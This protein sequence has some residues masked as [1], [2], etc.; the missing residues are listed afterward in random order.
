MRSRIEIDGDSM[1]IEMRETQWFL[2]IFLG[3]WLTGW[4]VA[5]VVLAQ[6]FVEKS[7]LVTLMFGV[8]F[9]TSWI[10]VAGVFLNSLIGRQ[11]LLFDQCGLRHTWD[12]IVTL[13]QRS[14]PLEEIRQ[15]SVKTLNVDSEGGATIGIVV[16]TRGRDL[17]FGQNLNRLERDWIA[18]QLDN[19]RKQLQERGRVDVLSDVDPAD[20]R[21][22]APPSDS[23]WDVDQ[24]QSALVICQNGKFVWGAVLGLLFVNAFWNGIVGLFVALLFGFVPGGHRHL[25]GEW[26]FLC[27][28]LIPFEIIGALI[29]FGLVLTILEPFRRTVWTFTDTNCVRATT[30]FNLPLGRRTSFQN[31]GISTVTVRN[32]D[33]RANAFSLARLKSTGPSTEA[34]ELFIA[35]REQREVCTI[36]GLT[37][38]EAQ[39]WKGQLQ[40]HFHI[41]D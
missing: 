16:S 25:S 7:E 40:D 17:S 32:T 2:N 37:I 15:I 30:R 36:N 6:K 11:R 18:F 10:F 38:G 29:G 12:V 19:H 24:T 27:L 33:E 14:I 28:F 23:S 22:L 31:D 4:T 39:W 5:C 9:W 20:C 34:Y 8:P 21:G 3:V 1:S 35:D 26:W 41:P 13:S